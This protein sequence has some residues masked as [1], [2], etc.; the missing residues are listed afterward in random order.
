MDKALI[1]ARV[2]TKEQAEEGYS[3]ASQIKLL[4]DYAE[5][6]S[7]DVVK[8][9]VIPESASGRQE[10]KTFKLMMDYCKK[11]GIGHILCEKVDRITRN[12]QDAVWI[13]A[14]LQEN[15]ERRIH[16]VK[17]NLVI[18]QNAKSY[19]KF[20][21]DIYVVLARQYSNN[22][23]EET[24]KG[25]LEKAEEGWY[26]GPNKR[27]YVTVGDRGHKVWEVDRS[28][29]SEAQ[30]IFKA[31][32]LYAQG[33]YTISTIREKLF[34][35]G[36]MSPGGR[37]LPRASI[38]TVL[39]DPFYCGKFIWNGKEYEG[40]HEPLIREET[41]ALAQQKLKR[42]LKNGKVRKH[43]F[44]YAGL[45]HCASCKSSV[46]AEVQK[47]HTYYRCTRYKPCDERKC[48]R[49]E[50][51]TAQMIHALD[52]LR[53]M[54][55]DVMGWLC[56]A[57]KECH[58]EEKVYHERVMKDLT[59][60]LTKIKARIDLL[61]DDRADKR[62]DKEFFE[63]RLSQYRRQQ[64]EVIRKIARHKEAAISYAKTANDI[65]TVSQGA[66]ELFEK[67][68]LK[69]KQ[70][71]FKFILSDARLQNGKLLFSYNEPFNKVHE[72][73]TFQPQDSRVNKGVL[74]VFQGSRSAMLPGLDDF[75][76]RA[77]SQNITKLLQEWF[78]VLE[79]PATTAEL[80]A[81]FAAIQLCED[82]TL[83]M[84]A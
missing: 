14:W 24:K 42:Q 54:Q 4:R 45:L 50:S 10:R 80:A 35:E 63:E 60:N 46:S 3:L 31:F 70:A 48:V 55:A 29:T 44:L 33:G 36:W 84:A 7:L 1:Y 82:H 43:E 52:A 77:S 75:P 41:F 62:I 17:Q 15:Q 69:D 38:H 58:E 27:G 64:Q 20:Q 71:L 18:H 11:R 49:E 74:E 32:T 83:A 67:L 16:F 34:K 57:L 47:G 26:P 8:E 25:L 12:L 66:R 68:E 56:R 22:L 72:I 5:K 76:T 53:V 6:N 2:S 40:K 59:N 28:A 81:R 23:S 78:G 37:M 65:L 19:E 9:F 51:I 30:F 73:A 13:D 61:Y 79:F 21:W 39:S